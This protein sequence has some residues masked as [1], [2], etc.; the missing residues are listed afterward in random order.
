MESFFIRSWWVP[1]LRG[2]LGILFGVLAIALPGL[3]LLA[4]IALFAAWALLAGCA[5]IAGA[6]RHR[7]SGDDWWVAF[8]LGAVSI[9]AGVVAVVNPALTALVLVLVMGANAL[10]T[11]ALDILAA[12][13]LRRAVADEWLLVLAGLAS[14]AFGAIVFLYPGAGALALVWLVSLYAVVSGGLL[15]GMAL[16]VR[17]LAPR[18][19]QGPERRVGPDRRMSLAR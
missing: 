9:G 7:R 11:G 17:K 14:L 5:S 10:V 18:A 12:V 2:V 16:R 15:L 3:T 13:R 8:L 4:L 19:G 1:A 6:L